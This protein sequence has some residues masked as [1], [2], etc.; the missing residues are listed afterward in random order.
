TNT[1]TYAPVR[2]DGDVRF[3]LDDQGNGVIALASESVWNATT[4]AWVV[5]TLS[6]NPAGFDYAVSAS[7][8]FLEFS[9]DLTTLLDLQPTCPP[10]FGSLGFRNVTGNTGENLKDFIKPL[11]LSAGSTCGQLK[12]VKHDGNGDL[13]GGATFRITPDPR[14][15]ASPAAYLDV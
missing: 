5:T 14:P 10:L 15:I 7:E 6:A 13:L 2:S 4:H 3:R 12:L 8:S 9:F 11:R 1:T